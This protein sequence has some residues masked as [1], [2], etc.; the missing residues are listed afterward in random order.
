MS[1]MR[2]DEI[3]Q[4]TPFWDFICDTCGKT[5]GSHWL[6]RPDKFGDVHPRFEGRKGNGKLYCHKD[7]A[8]YCGSYHQRTLRRSL[9]SAGYKT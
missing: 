4:R 9:E 1:M 6:F 7:Q 8:S 5:L 2:Q 3:G